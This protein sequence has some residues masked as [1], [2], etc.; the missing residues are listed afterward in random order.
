[1]SVAVLGSINLDVVLNVARLPKPGETVLASAKAHFQGG[2][3]ANQAVASSRAGARTLM[4]GAVGDDGI[5]KDL[6]RRLADYGV[7]IE[8]VKTLDG[9]DTGQ[10]HI[11]VSETGENS[12]VIISGAN[13]AV[14]CRATESDDVRSASVRLAQLE[15]PV[16]AVRSFFSNVSDAPGATR[17]LNAAPAIPEARELFALS[18]IIVVNE[19]E[20]EV[21]SQAH[22]DETT[23]RNAL[24]SAA[25]T[26]ITREGQR[27]VVTLGA[28]GCLM[29]GNSDE[30]AVAGYPASVVDTTGAGDCFCGVLAASLSNGETL[31]KAIHFANAAACLAVSKKGAGPSMPKLD[32]ILEKM[33]AGNSTESYEGK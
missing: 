3:G 15:V 6:L 30:L 9:T 16:D 7:G 17:I 1:M 28:K 10:A 4:L 23:A 32:E 25:R 22:I 24:V 12:I 14:A 21:F 33:A 27:V 2:K 18:D 19:T 31:E 13:R 20:L 26:L 11:F 29:V 8:N 5:G